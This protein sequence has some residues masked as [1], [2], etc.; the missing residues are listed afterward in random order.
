MS[1]TVGRA[2]APG[3]SAVAE[4]TFEAI[5]VD[6]DGTA[7]PDRRS[8]ATDV[9]TRVEA[10]CAAG[11]H[12]F[13]VSG[14]DVGNIDG[15][16]RAR[17][18][19]PGR[20]H[21]CLDRG[22]DVFRVGRDGPELEWR[23]TATAD[24]G[25]AL[26]RAA[27]LAVE[28]L[29]A[30]GLAAQLV[31][32]R[33]NR[34]KIDLIPEPAWADPPKACIGELLAAVTERLSAAGVA[35]LSDVVAT[36]MAAAREAGLDDPRITTDG[37]HVEVGLTDKSDSARW[38]ARWLA[39]RGITGGLILVGGDELGPL[40][41]VPGSDAHLLVPEMAR[42]V[43]VSVG[44]EPDGV[45]TGV[46]HAAG[47]PAEFLALF[48]AQL[49]R[50][51][52]RRV[53]TVDEDPAWVVSLPEEETM[54]RAA[55]ALGTLANGWAGLRAAREEDGPGTL[56]SFAV[57]GIYNAGPAPIL[58]S[59]PIWTALTVSG[60]GRATSGCSTCAQASCCAPAATVRHY[61]PC[62]SS[63]PPTLGSWRCEPRGR[64]PSSSPVPRSGHRPTAR[65][66]SSRIE[67][68]PASPGP[69]IRS[70]R[71]HGRGA[72]LPARRWRPQ[73]GR[74]ARRVGR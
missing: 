13:V 54:L 70:R 34:R 10:L 39:E 11:V 52:D 51:R 31:A 3:L 15:Q 1:E 66:W 59:G 65:R 29:A 43:V 23:R 37:K 62:G 6:W 4:R 67:G 53:P 35:S 47:G 63:R 21:L 48:D 64:P 74:T 60:T 55:E 42:A 28:R 57:N 9:C 8:D 32:E 5:L 41:G 26:D 61:G 58:L 7:V 27:S 14:T 18:V 49:A 24:E 12:V 71:D 44:V 46:V 50:R 22:S 72:G 17:P 73:S 30:R 56:P 20:L 69:R 2:P 36:V 40:G 16:L 25:L 33:V 45:P 68:Q 38:A 19:G